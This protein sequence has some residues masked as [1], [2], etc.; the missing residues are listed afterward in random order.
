[1]RWPQIAVDSETLLYSGAGVIDAE[2]TVRALL[3]QAQ[4]HGARVLSSWPVAGDVRRVPVLDTVDGRTLE[5][6]RVVVMPADG[7][8]AAGTLPLPA[9]FLAAFP[10]LQVTEENAFH[11]PYRELVTNGGRPSST[12]G[13]PSGSTLPGG[14]DARFRGQKMAEFL[15]GR[16]RLRRGQHGASTPRTARGSWT[17]P[18]VPPRPRP[19]ALRGDDLP[20]HQHPHR[21]LRRRRG[22]RD[23]RRLA[24]LRTRREVRPVD[25]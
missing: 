10:P 22:G 25:R 15:G 20:V 17:R 14:R 23:D 7:C 9:G 6:E 13:P 3:E 24:L 18:A 1:M 16:G 21:R 5:A 8:R 11:F 12:E 2:G 19:R 4:R